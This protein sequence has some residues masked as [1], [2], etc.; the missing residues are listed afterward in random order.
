MYILEKRLRSL[1]EEEND[2]GH[3]LARARRGQC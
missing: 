2:N 1:I 3:Q